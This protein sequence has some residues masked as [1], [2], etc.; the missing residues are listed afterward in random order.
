MDVW[1]RP[2]RMRIVLLARR[3]RVLSDDRSASVVNSISITPLPL[4]C[5][6]YYSGCGAQFEVSVLDLRQTLGS[7]P[8]GV[9]MESS[10]RC[11]CDFREEHLGEVF[12]R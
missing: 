8:D 5:I 7:V 2:H 11:A 4:S 10:L 6:A 3:R 12:Q 1:W 9:A